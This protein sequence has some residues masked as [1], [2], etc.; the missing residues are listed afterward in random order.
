MRTDAYLSL[1]EVA[2][3]LWAAA[4]DL[5][6]HRADTRASEWAAR[7]VQELWRSGRADDVRAVELLAITLEDKL[8]DV[9]A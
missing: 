9:P 8:G 3:R 2:D 4:Y 1:I 6:E 7:R 5:D